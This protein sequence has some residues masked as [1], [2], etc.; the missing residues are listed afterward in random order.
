MTLV[1]LPLFISSSTPYAKRTAGTRLIIREVTARKRWGWGFRPKVQW[2][3]V[4]QA[5]FSSLGSMGGGEYMYEAS[6][7]QITHGNPVA[8]C[9]KEMQLSKFLWV[10]LSNGTGFHADGLPNNGFYKSKVHK[11][12]GIPKWMSMKKEIRPLR[13]E[14]LPSLSIKAKFNLEKI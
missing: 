4:C 6:W 7:D 11:T 2:G 12:I 14:C 13:K 9:W 3:G 5:K 8:K 1:P 10:L